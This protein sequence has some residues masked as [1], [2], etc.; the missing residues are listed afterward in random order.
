MS[1]RLGY[2]YPE[3]LSGV[4]LNFLPLRRDAGLVE[5]PTVEERRYL[6]E[7]AL[8]LHE[9]A[10]HP[11]ANLGLRPDRLAR[12]VGCLDHREVPRLVRQ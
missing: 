12:G 7:L 6:N 10:G 2:A 1:A 3:R 5:D 9:E 11:A 8:F 4:H